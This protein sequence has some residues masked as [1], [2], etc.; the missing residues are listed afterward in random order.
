MAD[1]TLATLEE[2]VRRDPADGDARMIYR[3]ALLER[4]DP[5]GELLALAAETEPGARVAQRMRALEHAVR[6]SVQAVLP[7]KAFVL[8]RFA[9]GL[10]EHV[11]L[12][13]DLPLDALAAVLQ[14]PELV[15][16][17]GV[18]LRRCWP[19]THELR[20]AL[21]GALPDWLPAVTW[22]GVGDG[23]TADDLA[24]LPRLRGVGLSVRHAR[25]IVAK[26]AGIVDVELACGDISAELVALL[27]ERPLERVVVAGSDH[28]V[29]D[30][31]LGLSTLR[32]LGFLGATSEATLAFVRQLAEAPVLAQLTAFG[33]ACDDLEDETRDWIAD[34]DETF[35][36]VAWFTLPSDLR[37]R[38]AQWDDARA[39]L[40]HL[41]YDLDRE[42]EV[43]ALCDDLVVTDPENDWC[44]DML[45]DVLRARDRYAEALEAHVHA[46]E[47]DR[48]NCGAWAG[49]ADCLHELGQYEEALA[50]WVRAAALDEEEP[51]AHEGRGRTLWQLGRHDDA[52]A[53]FA[54][55]VKIDKDYA[56][57][58]RLRAH[59][60][61]AMGRFDEAYRTYER[62]TTRARAELA[63]VV[64]G[65]VGM[66][67][68]CLLRGERKA[69]REHWREAARRAKG[70]AAAAEPLCNLAFVRVAAGELDKALELFERACKLPEQQGYAAVQ[71]AWLLLDLGRADEALAAFGELDRDGD[72]VEHVLALDA[73]GR[74]REAVELL[75]AG[76]NE[77]LRDGC[78]TAWTLGH[79][80]R[81]A[82]GGGAPWTCDGPD[83]PRA[84]H[85]ALAERA[86]AAG[87]VVQCDPKRCAQ[88][89]AVVAL[90]AALLRRDRDELAR[91]AGALAADIAVHGTIESLSRAWAVRWLARRT[92][93]ADRVFEAALAAV[94][95]FAPP[96]AIRDQLVRR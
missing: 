87:G 48:R 78:V 60:L 52:L 7:A 46:C 61:R 15:A 74:T 13:G 36:H 4:G 55:A 80:V 39:N 59:L 45:G 85:A 90:L 1:A 10:V 33:I 43:L 89:V 88:D 73:L 96:S 71:R 67:H 49:R 24:R 27:A 51:F 75:A 21:L 16:V 42:D 77:P 68:V 31:V 58:R 40:A 86:R 91:R 25:P 95:G 2:A 53:A 79:V 69:A 14:R 72:D 64:D 20:R 47:I 29:L 12:I 50:A 83:E 11:E 62:C 56:S 17:R 82:L 9:D 5:R 32:G 38:D 6:A 35:K 8:C 26:L 28:R 23:A 54:Q 76:A 70:T 34:R 65:F 44:W 37:L 3:D 63:E 93:L 30:P 94:E 18:D 22:L 41:L 57:A 81:A 92:G 84:L 66:G 19:A